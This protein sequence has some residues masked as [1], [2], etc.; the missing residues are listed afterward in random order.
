MNELE[1]FEYVV[2]GECDYSLNGV[3][4]S[5]EGMEDVKAI[6]AKVEELAK[7]MDEYLVRSPV[8]AHLVG[9]AFF[10]RSFHEKRML[11]EAI[12]QAN[13]NIVFDTTSPE[14]YY[15]YDCYG[16]KYSTPSQAVAAWLMDVAE[17]GELNQEHFDMAMKT[18]GRYK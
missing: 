8:V 9:R 6:A 10:Y 2:K 1:L 14:V 3:C 4:L 17:D 12:L 16:S 5:K 18:L 13:G 15:S 7:G 11:K